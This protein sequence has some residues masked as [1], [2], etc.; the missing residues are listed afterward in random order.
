MKAW[1]LENLWIAYSYYTSLSAPGIS[2]RLSL[3]WALFVYIHVCVCVYV[4]LCMLV[5]IF[6]CILYFYIYS[7]DNFLSAQNTIKTQFSKFM[8]NCI[9]NKSKLNV[10]VNK[11]KLVNKY[12]KENSKYIKNH[13]NLN[14]RKILFYKIMI[15]QIK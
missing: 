3:P 8:Q 10:D 9:S 11:L 14:L 12:F 13:L 5:N 1:R 2:V 6:N 4:S 15:L 7:I